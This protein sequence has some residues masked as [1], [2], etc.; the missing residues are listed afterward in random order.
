MTQTGSGQ[1]LQRAFQLRSAKGA[2]VRFS[3][4]EVTVEELRVL[5]MIETEYKKYQ[6]ELKL[7]PH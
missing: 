7:R 3:S 2:G 1:I 4:D 5:I 6:E